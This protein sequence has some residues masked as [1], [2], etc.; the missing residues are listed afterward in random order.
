[1]SAD[2]AFVD[3]R[4]CFSQKLKHSVPVGI[5]ERER[6]L[7]PG[8]DLGIHAVATFDS[9]QLKPL[10][11][12]WRDAN[13]NCEAVLRG[14]DRDLWLKGL[15]PEIG[16]LSAINVPLGATGYPQASRLIIRP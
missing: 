11:Q 6:S 14:H 2:R 16:A 1:M 4:S 15:Q 5:V 7:E 9:R 12:R 13:M 3:D 8:N 10:E